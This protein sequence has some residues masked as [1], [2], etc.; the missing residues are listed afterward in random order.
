MSQESNFLKKTLFLV[1]GVK[2]RILLHFPVGG[3]AY[4]FPD[5]VLGICRIR[6]HI[7]V[8][9]YGIISALSVENK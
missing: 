5:L 7:E 4:L 2:L 6:L 8:L 1:F 9:S 3:S